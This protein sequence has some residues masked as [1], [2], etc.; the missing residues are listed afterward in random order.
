M[1]CGLEL[2]PS[3]APSLSLPTHSEVALSRDG[4]TWRK[5]IPWRMRLPVAYTAGAGV[6]LGGGQGRTEFAFPPQPARYVRFTGASPEGR[7]LDI[8]L[9]EGRRGPAEWRAAEV[10]V[11]ESTGARPGATEQEAREIA[12]YL[13]E[14]G[15]G[16]TACDRWLSAR[17]LARQPAGAAPCAFPLFEYPGH[18][19]GDGG[20]APFW[21]FKPAA[22]TA[23][24][25]ALAHAGEQASLL[26]QALGRGSPWL[27][28]E[29]GAYASF[30]FLPSLPPN[31]PA[32]VWDGAR[33]IFE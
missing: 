12:G 28:S 6:Y 20:A 3:D 30:V 27:F 29:H 13:A 17:L 22:Q 10:R 16:F 25:V 7:L 24:I 26:R 33:L 21:R 18:L 9:G 14:M 32:L 1:V 4:E 2:L 8:P 5:V 15:V 19:Q 23:L 31:P 11:Y